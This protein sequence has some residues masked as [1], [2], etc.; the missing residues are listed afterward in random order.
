MELGPRGVRAN[1]VCPTAVVTEMGIRVCGEEA[2]SAPMLARIPAGLFATPA[3]VAAAVPYLI[4]AAAEMIDG[5]ESALDG[6]YLA[7]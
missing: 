3:D 6:G 1:S 2:R 5:T 4:S 7:T